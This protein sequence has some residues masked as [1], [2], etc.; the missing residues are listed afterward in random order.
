[1]VDQ[2]GQ[3]VAGT[4]VKVQIERRVT[5]AARVKGA[6]NAY[7]TQ[8]THQWVAVSDCELV[9]T[10]EPASCQ[11]TPDAPG[12][13]RIDASIQD[14]K[15]R[16]HSSQLYQYVVGKGRVIWQERAD[17]SLEIIAEKPTYHVG[18]KARYLIKNP[19]PGATALVSIE[20]YG[21]LKSWVQTLGS[22][23]PMI[24]FEVQQ[25][26]IPG[27][28]LSVVVVSPRVDQPP[29][30]WQVDLGKPTFRMGYV[31]VPVIDP[32]KEVAVRVSPAQDAYKPRERVK[33][34][35]QAKPRHADKKEP[36][37]L[38]VV[39]LDES[40][41]D[42]ISRGKSYFDPYKGFYT[43][44]GLDL[45]NFSLLMRLVGRQKFEK[46]GADT[47]GG[48]GPDLSL[49]SVFKFISYWNPSLMPDAEGKATV[50]FDAPDNLTGWR[51][52]VLAVTPGDR[53]GLGDASFKVNRPTEIRPVMPNQVTEGDGFLA[54]F[55]IMNRTAA[56]R[57]LTL[58]I[59]ARGVIETKP[60]KTLQQHSQSITAEPYK[61]Y[62][63]WMP[64]QSMTSGSIQAISTP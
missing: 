29:G 49:R 44:D 10:P 55:S 50:E 15:K 57:N 13:Y 41:F 39:V 64:V 14:T 21:V 53:M 22:G 18:D 4:P 24:E 42:L 56:P 30:D 25:D 26:F 5:K 62:T 38:A 60:A 19:F 52:L 45:E 58:A 37:E 3:P 35:I 43:I 47:G 8:Y 61:R 6:G 31:K 7:L 11:F 32:Y 33:V 46:K 23:T 27:Y 36:V 1:V 20:R 16:P 28:F 2:Q 48:G 12:S 9:S 63:I 54:G 51:V 59:S 40:V 34:N 17:N